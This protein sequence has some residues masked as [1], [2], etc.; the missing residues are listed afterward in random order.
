MILSFGFEYLPLLLLFFFLEDKP[1]YS[2]CFTSPFSLLSFILSIYCIKLSVSVA[3][4]LLY[5]KET[6]ILF[7]ASIVIS[8]WTSFSVPESLNYI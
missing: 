7:D 3:I 1:I 5:F 4:S 8:V 2:S 6:T